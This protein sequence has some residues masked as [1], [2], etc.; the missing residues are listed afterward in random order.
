MKI[1]SILKQNRQKEQIT[2]RKK[3]SFLKKEQVENAN[4]YKSLLNKITSSYK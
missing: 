1:T 2:E 3:I 4:L